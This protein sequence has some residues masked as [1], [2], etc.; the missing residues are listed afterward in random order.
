[1]VREMG[2]EPTRIYNSLPPQSS[3]S[4]CFAT[5]AYSLDDY[6]T[7]RFK[8]NLIYWEFYALSF[9]QSNIALLLNI[10][11]FVKTFCLLSNLSQI[12]SGLDIFTFIGL[13]S[14]AIWFF[15]L[16]SPLPIKSPRFNTLILFYPKI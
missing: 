10:I 3:A 15:L 13:A 9:S 4:T 2:L 5:L 7:S 16:F 11:S 1:M 14:L 8:Y 12:V 6:S